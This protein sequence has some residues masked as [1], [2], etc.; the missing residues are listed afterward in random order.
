[1][2]VSGNGKKSINTNIDRK[3]STSSIEERIASGSSNFVGVSDR[4]EKEV[5]SKINRNNLENEKLVVEKESVK[6]EKENNN[7]E[8][9][10]K[11]SVKENK[12]IKKSKDK[13]QKKKVFIPTPIEK[14]SKKRIAGI[15]MT[16]VVSSVF[17]SGV[18]YGLYYNCIRYPSQ[19][20]EDIKTSGLGGINRWVDSINTVDNSEIKPQIGVDS[21]LAKEI[22]YA[23]GNT[24][25]IEFIKKMIGTVDYVPNQIKATNIY[26]NPMISRVDD[27]IVFTD[28]LV[29]GTDEEV[30]L[31]Y[32]DYSKVP[33]D[34]E[35]IKKLVK[36]NNIKIG[37]GDYSNSL[38]EI[39]CTYM[40]SLDV[41]DIPLVS[42]KHVPNM[43]NM[44]GMYYMTED[45]DILLDKAL[46]SSEDFHDLLIRFSEVAAKGMENPAW[47]EWSK[48]SD[49]DKEGKTEPPK[50]LESLPTTSAWSDWNSKS[51]EEKK[52]LEEPI[53]YD[54]SKVMSNSWCGSYYLLNEFKSLD[55]NGNE[56]E[57]PI[58]AE[59]GDG[60]IENPADLNTGIVTSMFVSDTEGNRVAK[61]IKVR[62]IDYKVSAD[63][64]KYFESKDTRN[65]GY[66]IK[67]E[68]QYASYVFEVTNLSGEKLTIYD[69]SSLSDGQANL[70]PRTGT[71]YGL[72]NS[73]TLEPY[74]TGII[75]SWG[76]STELNK[77]YLIWGADFNR[78]VP[79]VWFRELAG[80]IDDPS[81]D[82]GVTLNKTRDEEDK[83]I[84]DTITP[85][86]EETTNT[87]E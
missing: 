19:M 55:S 86:D 51:D 42:I 10:K 33:L 23:N 17:L 56:V 58:E 7:L 14:L 45:E 80:D 74:Q 62:L 79:V 46:F 48:L 11:K 75:E 28:S 27:K 15:V 78:E 29:N 65:R 85:T 57:K 63:A 69:N 60:T 1:M 71:V 52:N 35:V 21:Y 61:P 47:V 84:E 13:K 67:S 81:E 4:T 26:G 8:T 82:K 76:C 64:L 66:D 9:K 59:V 54:S 44:N 16:G 31:K 32:I 30:K 77:K 25:K 68:V 6:L 20:K 3:T 49:K 53:K 36:D 83:N 40:N 5:N 70:A 18:V 73:V 43:V 24:N 50:V 39:F 12:K 72:Q 37:Y 38:V 2:R 22:E 87:V 41:E 34:E